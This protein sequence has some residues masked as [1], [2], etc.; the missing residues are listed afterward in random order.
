LARL[1][2]DGRFVLFS[3]EY[4]PD[5]WLADLTTGERRNLTE[6]SNRYNGSPQW[7]PGQ[8]DVIIFGSSEMLGPGFGNPTTVRTDS[9]DYRV[10]DEERSGPLAL[11]T[12][13]E[14]LAYGGFDHPGRIVRR[15]SEPEDTAGGC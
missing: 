14:L 13:G 3:P 1:S 15:G 11:S 9:S 8:E 12:D 4:D 6:S 7:W 2:A 5:I 10:L